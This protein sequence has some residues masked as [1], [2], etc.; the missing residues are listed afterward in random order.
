MKIFIVEESKL[1]RDQLIGVLSAIDGAEI[2]GYASSAPE[3]I[4]MIRAHKPDIVILDVLIPGGGIDTI[5]KIKEEPVV[6]FVLTNFSYNQYRKVCQAA[7]ADFF[8][9]KS[10]D[11]TRFTKVIENMCE[12]SI[13][14]SAISA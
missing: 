2:A 10:V 1:L 13:L 12:Q 14:V 6:V 4:A 5:R 9:D 3:A 7:G 11:F 8:F